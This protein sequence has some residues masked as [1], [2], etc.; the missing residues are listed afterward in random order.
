MQIFRDAAT[1]FHAADA[2]SFA[3][4]AQ[5]KRL[6][7]AAS[8]LSSVADEPGR[9]VHLYRV[10]FDAG[11]RTNWHT[12]SGQQWLFIIGGR[13]RVQC[14]GGAAEDVLAGDAVLFAPG[15][16]HWHGATPGADGAHLAVN[17]NATTTWLEPVS[18]EDYDPP[19]G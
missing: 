12:H 8:A 16:K 9:D 14:W 13:V 18:D 10:H 19:A 7:S 2:A 5:T 4:P 17:I 3:G 6:A 1:P 15:E 11:G